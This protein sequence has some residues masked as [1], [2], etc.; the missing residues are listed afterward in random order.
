VPVPTADAD[1]DASL[2]DPDRVRLRLSALSE[3]VSAGQRR[4]ARAGSVAVPPMQAK[5][6]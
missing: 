3:G 1:A 4:M 6:R 2:I 5:E